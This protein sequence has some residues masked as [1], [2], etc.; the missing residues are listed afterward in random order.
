M[1]PNELFE[2]LKR[3]FIQLPLSMGININ[4]VID[5]VLWLYRGFPCRKANVIIVVEK[6]LESVFS[7]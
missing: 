6:L 3:D 1:L 4:I 2:H 5:Y 7:L